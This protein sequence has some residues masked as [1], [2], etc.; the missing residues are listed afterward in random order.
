M[1]FYKHSP[2]EKPSASV[3]VGAKKNSC[4][5]AMHFVSMMLCAMTCVCSG[6][7]W[8]GKESEWY[9]PKSLTAKYREGLTPSKKE[10]M[11]QMVS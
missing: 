2:F 4:R 9:M 11:R 3:K 5:R 8:R 6:T 7:K 1:N 10:A